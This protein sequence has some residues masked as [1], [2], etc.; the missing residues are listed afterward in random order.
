MTQ[1]LIPHYFRKLEELDRMET[2]EVVLLEEVGL[3]CYYKKDNSD[4]RRFLK[5][6]GKRIFEYLIENHQLSIS[7]GNIIFDNEVNTLYPRHAEK[8]NPI[9]KEVYSLQNRLLEEVGL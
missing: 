9:T 7:N 8:D 1:P 4:T 6:D 2:P 5:R 3:V